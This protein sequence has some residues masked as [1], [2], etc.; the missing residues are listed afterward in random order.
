MDADRSRKIE[1]QLDIAMRA[2]YQQYL[3][4]M[5]DAAAHILPRLPDDFCREYYLT[6]QEPMNFERFCVMA[7]VDRLG[8]ADRSKLER[9]L[10][11]G[12]AKRVRESDHEFF[13]DRLRTIMQ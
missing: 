4:Y 2:L 5:S 6:M 7:E 1:P 8:A 3:Q 11:G 10:G 9:L 12:F 13:A